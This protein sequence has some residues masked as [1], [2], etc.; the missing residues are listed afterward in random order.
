MN[1]LKGKYLTENIF[2]IRILALKYKSKN[3]SYL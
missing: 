3:E 2:S 1:P